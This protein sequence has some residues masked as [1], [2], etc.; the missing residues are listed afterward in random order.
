MQ[1]SIP[2]QTPREKE[3]EMYV[4]RKMKWQEDGTEND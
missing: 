1:Q 4:E 2:S 3:Q